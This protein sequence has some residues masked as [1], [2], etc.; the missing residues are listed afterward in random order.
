MHTR[1]ISFLAAC[2]LCAPLLAWGQ[3]SG[4]Q[5]PPKDGV[6]SSNDPRHMT[7]VPQG[8]I[9]V[10]GAWSSAS[11]SVTPM[12]EDGKVTDNVFNDRYFGMTWALPPDWTEGYKGPP[13]SDTGRYVLAEI[14]PANTFKG[15]ARGSILITADDLFFTP[16]P[17]A[18]SVELISFTKENLQAD[19]KVE[20]SPTQITIGGRPFTFFAYW[21]PAA[22]L[23]WYVLATEIRCHTVEVVLSSSDT[24][25]LDEL[26]QEFNRMKLPAEESLTGSD[27]VPVCIKDYARDENVLERVDPVFIERR[28]NAVPVRIIIDKEGKIKHIHFLSAFPDQA[29]VISDA[30]GQWKFKPF[31]RNGEP[32]EVETGIMFGYAPRPAVSAAKGPAPK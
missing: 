18:N 20:R 32:V 8:V 15:P 25:M 21:S 28:F 16:L 29:R 30:L 4:L 9:L 3:A 22:G 13:P 6:G 24:K 14:V 10:K 17:V 2:A 7:K 1:S 26:M 5:E 23:H 31:M 12:P 19:Y 11:D 27:A